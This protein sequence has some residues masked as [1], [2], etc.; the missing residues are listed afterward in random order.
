MS[1]TVA[2][3]RELVARVLDAF[4][5]GGV[6]LPGVDGKECIV[7]HALPAHT[8]ACPIGQLEKLLTP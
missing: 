6:V 2:V 5:D 3:P 1:A 7:C 4:E 8:P